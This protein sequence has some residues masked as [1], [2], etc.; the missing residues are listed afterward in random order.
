MAI[1][2]LEQRIAALEDEVRALKPDIK[3]IDDGLRAIPELNKAELSHLVAELDHWLDAMD[4]AVR[5]IAKKQARPRR[6]DV[7]YGRS[8]ARLARHVSERTDTPLSSAAAPPREQVP[9]ALPLPQ[10]SVDLA[11]GHGAHAQHSRRHFAAFQLR[12]RLMP[13][14]LDHDEEAGLFISGHAR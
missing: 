6:S 5:A 14:Q 8:A 10:R 7:S 13:A 12:P 11:G 4:V 9:R 1:P 3:A 2:D